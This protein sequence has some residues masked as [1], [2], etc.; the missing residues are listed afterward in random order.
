M[1]LIPSFPLLGK[2]LLEQAARRRT[3]AARSLFAILLLLGFWIAYMSAS[4][5]LDPLV[6][7]IG[8][9]RELFDVLLWSLFTGILVLMP[10]LCS[11]AITQ[12]K[13]QGSLVLLML[14]P[15]G[16][17]ELVLQKFTASALGMLTLLMLAMP[18]MALAYAFG[19]V[20]T[21]RIEGGILM[22]ALTCAQTGALCLAV[23]A[24]CRGSGM[25]FFASYIGLV[26][27]HLLLPLRELMEFLNLSVH[28]TWTIPVQV[29]P[30]LQFATWDQ[31]DGV[32]ALAARNWP[33]MV[34]IVLLLVAARL[35]I[36]RRAQPAGGPWMLAWFR[37]LDARFNGWERRMGR[38]VRS[39]VPERDPVAWREINR[40]ALASWRYLARIAL[41]LFALA[42]VFMRWN[43]GRDD[44][45]AMYALMSA[46]GLVLTAL[47]LVSL[48][49]GVMAAERAQQTLDVLLTTPMSPADILGQKV[50]ALSRV[51]LVMVVM[52]LA[53]VCY[54]WYAHAMQHT[55]MAAYY[56]SWYLPRRFDTD[57]TSKLCAQVEMAVLVPPIVTWMSV[58]VGMWVRHR[59]R[60]VATALAVLLAWSFGWVV[61]VVGFRSL[62]NDSTDRELVY[63]LLI[64]SPGGYLAFSESDG[65]ERMKIGAFLPHL[66]AIGIYTALWLGLRFRCLRM[67]PRLLRKSGGAS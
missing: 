56:A 33:I 53:I 27:I 3:Y 67:A 17:W 46:A 66:A 35:A 10:A 50:R 55:I 64:L 34:S 45:D 39:E 31:T 11:S 21:E 60:A 38:T 44:G 48:G 51:Q 5:E 47:V 32:M 25:A 54:R 22:L 42:F 13:E 41:P 12:E 26:V 43:F 30:W 15:M 14:T 65:L 4:R 23:S 8:R 59:G 40:R 19:G 20:S 1:R 7:M 29:T 49:T 9:G 6:G 58:L 62:L 36:I 16:P 28:G 37:S 61:L 2:E 52:L 63:P 57:L 24:Y 18:L